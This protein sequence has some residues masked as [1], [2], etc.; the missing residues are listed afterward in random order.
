MSDVYSPPE[1]ELLGNSF[2]G[3]PP[4]SGKGVYPA[5]VGLMFSRGWEILQPM[6][7]PCGLGA[8]ALFA[9]QMMVNIPLT[10]I[11]TIVQQAIAS[12]GDETV[13]AIAAVVAIGMQFGTSLIGQIANA[14]LMLGLARASHLLVTTGSV[15]VGD[16]LPFDLSLIFK[17]FLA[18]LLY[19][20]VVVAGTCAFIV[21]G[22]IAAFGLMLWPYAM[23]VEGLGP[24]DALK[25]SWQLT[26]GAKLHLFLFGLALG[27]ASIFV[28]PL[29]LCLGLFAILPFT[30]IGYALVFEGARANKPGLEYMG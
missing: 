28:V 22:F 20:L 10:V 16:F 14:F 26:D 4:S 17:G 6:L 9:I 19:M 11:Q 15:E 30:Y 1:S 23:I 3:P 21:P 12:S 25:R 5:D 29:T 2:D 24:V 18:Q 13:Q 7:V 27:V 8:L